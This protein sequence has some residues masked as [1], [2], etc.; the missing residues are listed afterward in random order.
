MYRSAY[1]LKAPAKGS[2][3]IVQHICGSSLC[4]L[5]SVICLLIFDVQALR[6]PQPSSA[7]CWSLKV[8]LSQTE[9][10]FKPLRQIR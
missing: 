3:N 10:C 7:L 4:L 6:F 9:V 1:I 2:I 8:G 5:Q